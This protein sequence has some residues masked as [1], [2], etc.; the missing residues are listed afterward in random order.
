VRVKLDKLGD[1]IALRAVVR[2]AAPSAPAAMVWMLVLLLKV[3][4]LP[5]GFM[6]TPFGMSG[7]SSTGSE[8]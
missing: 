7:F 1:G 4:I 6:V 3:C 8:T 5:S 2:V